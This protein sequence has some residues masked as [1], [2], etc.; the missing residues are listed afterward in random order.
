MSSTAQN[1]KK[2]RIQVSFEIIGL[3]I[4][5]SIVE[6]KQIGVCKRIAKEILS[7]EKEVASDERRIQKMRDEGRDIHDI[8]KQV[9]FLEASLT[10]RNLLHFTNKQ[11]EVLQESLMM[12]Q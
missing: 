6:N 5:P 3:A 2:L 11:E 8:R 12:V 1:D 7:Y 10:K 9:H 4:F